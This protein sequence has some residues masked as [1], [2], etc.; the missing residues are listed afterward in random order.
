MREIKFKV[1]KEY[2]DGKIKFIGYETIIDGC[3]A[4]SFGGIDWEAATYR[5]EKPGE[6]IRLQYIGFKD[7]NGKEICE[8]DILRD[9]LD[10]DD[11]DK[12]T[13]I[14]KNGRFQCSDDDEIFL[15]WVVQDYE[16][17]GN[18]YENPKLP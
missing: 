7:K 5:N 11:D 18:I 2:P 6:L 4:A 16:V 8:V 9:A 10:K 3:W 15:E 1:I 12:F 13:I 14:W 17:I